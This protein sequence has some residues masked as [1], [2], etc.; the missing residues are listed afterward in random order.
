MDIKVVINRCFGGFGLSEKAVKLYK[1][2]SG[3]DIPTI[4]YILSIL[5]TS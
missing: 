3:R 4:I 1:E 5:I 2:K